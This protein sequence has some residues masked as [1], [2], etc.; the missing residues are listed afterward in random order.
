M[1]KAGTHER[2][3]PGLAGDHQVFQPG[4]FAKA[5]GELEPRVAERAAGLARLNRELR[6]IADCN[7]TLLRASGEQSLLAVGYG[8]QF[9]I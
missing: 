3:R 4:G 1:R 5:G 2:Y 7:Q 9:A 6:A 8:P